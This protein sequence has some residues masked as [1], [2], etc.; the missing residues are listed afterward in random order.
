MSLCPRRAGACESA[1]HHFTS[2]IGQDHT[3]TI[4]QNI[5]VL[6]R[7]YRAS[8][9]R[10]FLSIVAGRPG[11]DHN[12][13]RWAGMKKLRSVLFRPLSRS[14]AC[15]SPA[16]GEADKIMR[17]CRRSHG[18]DHLRCQKEAGDGRAHSLLRHKVLTAASTFHAL[19]GCLRLPARWSTRCR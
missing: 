7:F 16:T 17:A 18:R 9:G 12:L 8:Q 6:I 2:A 14:R 5:L 3:A 10:R 15:Y 11:P 13:T 4:D 19:I 1:E